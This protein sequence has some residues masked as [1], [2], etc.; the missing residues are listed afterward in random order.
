M[1]EKT[2][3]GH[4]RK[5][6]QFKVDTVS[7]GKQFWEASPDRYAMQ[8]DR[9][10][11]SKNRVVSHFCIF[12]RQRKVTEMKDNLLTAHLYSVLVGG[13]RGKHE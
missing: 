4:S 8:H 7:R 12:V 3:V 9:E 6:H 1:L 13:K 2:T 5:G 11:R 10:T